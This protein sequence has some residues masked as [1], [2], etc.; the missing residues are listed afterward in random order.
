MRKAEEE[1][2]AFRV[3]SLKIDIFTLTNV[4]TVKARTSCLRFTQD[5]QHMFGFNSNCEKFSQFNMIICRFF[6][7][8]FIVH[9]F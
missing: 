2:L 3:V 4:R 5:V 7:I 9:L 8:V 6:I 1:A